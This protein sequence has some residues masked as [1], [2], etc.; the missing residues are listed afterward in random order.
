MPTCEPDKFVGRENE[1]EYITQKIARL[2]RGDP[3][4]PYER[5]I[6][7]I[8]PSGIG[9]SCLLEK[10]YLIT[11]IIPECVP[12][13]IKLE[14]LGKRQGE[15][16]DKFLEAVDEEFSHYQKVSNEK[17]NGRTPLKFGSDITKKINKRAE[18]KIIVLF[19]DEINLPQKNEL[20]SIEEH[21]LERLFQ[22]NNRVVL[23]TAGRSPAMWNEF[24]L[25]PNPKNTFRLSAF[26]ERTTGEQLDKLRPGSAH[27]AGK[28]LEL[29]GGVPGNNKEL[30]E[31]IVGNPL[32][33]AN[34]L[35]AVQSLVVKIKHEIDERH[36]FLLEAICI[37]PAFHPEDAA[38]L[39]ESHPALGGHWDEVRIRNVFTELNQVRVGPGGLI[40]W[41]REKKSWV[42]DEPTRQLFERELQM[43]DPELWKKLHCTAYQMYKKWGEELNSQLYKDKA[44]YHRQ[45]LQSTGMDCDDL[46]TRVE[47]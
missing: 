23:I 14:T 32:V 42:M 5:V 37:L 17:K 40:N 6:H 10:C 11:D 22:D 25:R 46:E 41:D 27:L 39:L 35:Q 47:Q 29:G 7:I 8:G 15:F 36:H 38:P 9:K 26:D 30:A 28:F 20:Q 44:V 1:L 45:C 21:L 19:L 2:A 34:D 12:V 3:F 4:A 24:A 43:R 16:I 13:L 31:H 33:I 18:D